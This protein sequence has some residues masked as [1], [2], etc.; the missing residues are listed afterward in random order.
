LASWRDVSAARTRAKFNEG[1]AVI[2]ERDTC[3][4]EEI[5]THPFFTEFLVRHGLGCFMATEVAPAH[6]MLVAISVQRAKAKGPFDQT[7][8]TR[9]VPLGRHVEQALKLTVRLMRSESA[10]FALG[11]ALS[12]LSCGVFLLDPKQQVLFANRQAQALLGSAFNASGMALQPIDR[13][14]RLQ[15]AA[16]LDLAASGAAK[17]EAPQSFMLRRPAVF[18]GTAAPPA[19]MVSLLPLHRGAR[20]TAADIFGTATTMV[21]VIESSPSEPPDAAVVRDLLGLTLGE[22]RVAALIGSG[23]SPQ[24]AALALDITEGTARTVLKRVFGKVGVSRQSELTALLSRLA[25]LE[26]G[27]G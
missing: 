11:E 25:W 12:R 10:S 19:M 7:D 23:Q 5:A 14:S 13:T 21:L 2:T 1:F 15:L 4:P 8:R 16:A 20:G 17:A 22:A 3:T 27:L 18:P 9:I 24:Q 6:D 26:P